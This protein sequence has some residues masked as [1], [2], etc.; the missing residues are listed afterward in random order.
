MNPTMN[1]SAQSIM[2]NVTMNVTVSGLRAWRMR[3]WL[4][5]QFIKLAAFVMGCGFH[6]EMDREEFE[7]RDRR[8]SL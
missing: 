8:R 7:R 3:L 5:A 1:I 4:G 6:I 2:N